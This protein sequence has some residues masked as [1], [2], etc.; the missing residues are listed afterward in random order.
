MITIPIKT[1]TSSMRVS[2]DFYFSA[3]TTLLNYFLSAVCVI[4]L[5]RA[6]TVGHHINHG[7]TQTETV[8][9]KLVLDSVAW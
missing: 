2:I 3:G 1:I 4:F 8:I 7:A 5:N 6:Y 9:I